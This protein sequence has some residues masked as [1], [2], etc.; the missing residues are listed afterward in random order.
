[1]NNIKKIK[2]NRNCTSASLSNLQNQSQLQAQMLK[3][4][5]AFNN[6]SRQKSSVE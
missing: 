3:A 1:M 6:K 5:C 2:R 4:C